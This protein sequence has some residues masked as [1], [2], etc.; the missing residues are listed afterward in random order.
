MVQRYNVSVPGNFQLWE[1]FP[2]TYLLAVVTRLRDLCSKKPFSTLDPAFMG[3]S[4]DLSILHGLLSIGL[5]LSND[6]IVFELSIKSPKVSLYLLKTN[7][8]SDFSCR[9]SIACL[10]TCFLRIGTI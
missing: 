4:L 8:I 6:S 10:R 9:P 3:M 5:D 1:P 2:A 7:A